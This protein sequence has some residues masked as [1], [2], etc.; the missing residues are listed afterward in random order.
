MNLFKNLKINFFEIRKWA[1]ATSFLIISAGM[2]C[3]KKKGI[4]KSVELTGGQAWIIR[5]DKNIEDLESIKNG[6]TEGFQEASV[7]VTTYGKSNVL[8]ITTNFIE[9]NEGQEAKEILIDSLEKTTGKK[10]VK[11]GEE[12]NRLSKNTFTIDSS[13]KIGAIIADYI[14]KM[15]FWAILLALLMIFMYILIRFRRWQFGIAAILALAHDVLMVFA[16]IGIAHALGI[17]YEADQIFI[18]AVLTVIGYSINDTVV[19]FDRFR[20]NLASNHERSFKEIANLSIN[21]TMSRTLITSL[22]TLIAAFVLFLFG[23]EVLRGFSFTLLIGF[24]FGTFSSIF[25]LVLAHD[26]ESLLGKIMRKKK[27]KKKSSVKKS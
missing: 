11:G 5:M 2:F 18:G 27:G 15:A 20:E 10:Y 6:L 8:K 22:T 25:S 12:G 19:V 4:A 13:T 26:L 1:Y 16:A 17:I 3:I 9:K 21:E 24:I 7:Q 23:G 14:L